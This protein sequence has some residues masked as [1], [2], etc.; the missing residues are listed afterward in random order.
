MFNFIT[1]NVNGLRDHNKRMSFLQWLSHLSA[2]I[3]CLQETHVS[4]CAEA[5]F[6]FSSYGFLAL[7]SPGSIHSC[8]SVILYRPT[9]VLVKSSID[10]QGRFVL[11]HFKKDDLIFGVACLYAPNRNPSRNDFFDYCADQM[12]LSVPTLLCGDFN[13]VFDRVLDRRGPVSDSSRES[14][15][16]LSNL[17]HILSVS[18]IWRSVHPDSVA[19]TWLRPDGSQSSRIDLIGCPTSWLHLVASCEILPCPFSDHSAVSLQCEIPV[20]FPRSPG[21]WILNTAILSDAD[22]VSSVRDFWQV[23]KLKKSAFSSLSKW[24]DRGK[25]RIKGIAV[26]FCCIKSKEKHM[27][28]SLWSIL[29]SHLK[30]KID[31]GLVSLLPVYQNVLAKLASLDLVDAQGAKVRSRVKW[32]EEGETSSRYFLNLEKRRG[33]SDWI[34]GM[35]SPD[36]LVL[37]G[38]DDICDSWRDFYSSLFTA[39]PI[40]PVAQADLLSNVSLSLT[41]EQSALCEGHLA[42]DEVH[43]ALLGMARNKS[44]GSDG[45]PMEFYLSFWDVLGSDLVEVFNASFDSGLLP[46]SQRSALISLIFKKGDRLLHKNWRPISLLN[47]DY[48]ILARTLAGRLLKVLHFV[49]HPD[50]TCGVRGRYIGENV[51]LLRDV[52]SFVNQED[53]AAAILSLD[54]E[55]TFDRV[56]WGFLRS[57]L[58]HMGFGPSFVSWVDLLYSEI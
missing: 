25:E 10:R 40:D 2:D 52:V 15:V 23:W 53:L 14:S 34:S 24:W 36:G 57:T 56:D 17:F 44:P 46:P 5:D 54:Q 41:A 22:F 13:T 33:A 19:F 29:A 47:V 4:S 50:Q 43:A 16:A 1:V 48:K 38:I 31:D 12:D 26:Q 7:S 21:R 42:Q 8:G 20:P 49:I 11:A 55:K 18:D 27:S 51:S 58:C 6:W 9:F 3:V 28:R 35:K 39:C 45:L 37:T 32:A 30:F